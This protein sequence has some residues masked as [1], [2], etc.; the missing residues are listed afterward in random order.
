MEGDKLE[1]EDKPEG[2]DKPRHYSDAILGEESQTRSTCCAGTFD[3]LQR[4]GLA[5][6]LDDFHDRSTTEHSRSRR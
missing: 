4:R 2:G 3:L 5:I 6:R 1:G